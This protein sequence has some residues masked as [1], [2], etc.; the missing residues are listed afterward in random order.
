MA[1]RD[2]YAELSTLIHFVIPYTPS[3]FC[4]FLSRTLQ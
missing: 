4:A 2:W 3:H 1:E